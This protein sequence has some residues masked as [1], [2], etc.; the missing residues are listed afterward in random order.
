MHGAHGENDLLE[1]VLLLLAWQ[2]KKALP[3]LDGKS[4]AKRDKRKLFRASKGGLKQKAQPTKK[5]NAFFQNMVELFCYGI[6][7]CPS[8]QGS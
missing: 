8:I 4:S 6:S 5:K 3:S 2:A 7:Q 1:E